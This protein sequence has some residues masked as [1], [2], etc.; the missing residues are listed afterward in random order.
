MTTCVETI[1]K[2]IPLIP[3]DRDGA[4]L[5]R[6]LEEFVG[7]IL[8]E[9]PEDGLKYWRPA[10]TIIGKYIDGQSFADG[11]RRDVFNAWLDGIK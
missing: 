10:A 4:D 3:P 9:L 2:I 7:D 5:R 1:K 6:E 11:W 8:L